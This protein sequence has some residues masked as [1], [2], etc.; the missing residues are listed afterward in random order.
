MARRSRAPFLAYHVPICGL[1]VRA[2]DPKNPRHIGRVIPEDPVD[3]EKGD[4]LDPGVVA[5][6]SQIDQLLAD[7]GHPGPCVRLELLADPAR[8][9]VVATWQHTRKSGQEGRAALQ[10]E[11]GAAAVMAE[12]VA[13]IL[14]AAGSLVQTQNACIEQ[15]SQAL[16]ARDERLYGALDGMTEAHRTAANATL[17]AA[18]MVVEGSIVAEDGEPLPVDTGPLNQLLQGVAQHLGIDI[19]GGPSPAPDVAPKQ[20]DPE[21]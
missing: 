9:S 6:E 20:P 21:G 13:S 5:L 19:S 10:G 8:S 2:G 12:S 7:A 15:L 4:A 17:D 18:L 14:N 1:I 11:G 16:V 3:G